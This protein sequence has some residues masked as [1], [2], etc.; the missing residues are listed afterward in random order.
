MCVWKMA[1]QSEC[2]VIFTTFPQI[3]IELFIY[4]SDPWWKRPWT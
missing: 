4:T 2:D 1:A 3:N